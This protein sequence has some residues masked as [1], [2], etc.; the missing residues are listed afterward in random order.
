MIKCL[1]FQ[2]WKAWS[3]ANCIYLNKFITNL[4]IG[5][6]PQHETKILGS[7]YGNDFYNI[8][9]LMNPEKYGQPSG[10][11]IKYIK[12]HYIFFMN[13]KFISLINYY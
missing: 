1:F 8:S 11:Y 13:N 12:L 2:N 4:V 5:G 7:G 10:A 3:S 6:G 9:R